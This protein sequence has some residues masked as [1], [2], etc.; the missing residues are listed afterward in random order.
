[1]TTTL[2]HRC[3]L[4]NQSTDKVSHLAKVIRLVGNWRVELTW[5]LTLAS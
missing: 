4:Q 3:R 1:M 2:S 5:F